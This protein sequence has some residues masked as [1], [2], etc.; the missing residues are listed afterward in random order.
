M[1]FSEF[2]HNDQLLRIRQTAEYPDTWPA[3]YSI[4]TDDRAR[5]W[6][7]SITADE[8]EF[9]WWV[10]DQDGEYARFVWPAGREIVH[11][12]NGYAYVIESD[13]AGFKD[14]VRYRIS[15]PE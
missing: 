6:V 11:V 8:D 13:R 2:S 10:I 15:E 14:V 5:L 7:S 3:L 9:I 12:Q 4:V 1:V